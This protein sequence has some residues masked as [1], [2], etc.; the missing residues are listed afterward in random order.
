M[1]SDDVAALERELTALAARLPHDRGSPTAGRIPFDVTGDAGQALAT[2]AGLC[3]VA[4]ST[5]NRA[6]GEQVRVILLPYADWLVPAGDLA[7]IGPLAGPLGLLCEGLDR[8]DQAEELLRTAIT[9]CTELEA[10]RWLAAAQVE[11]ASFYQRQGTHLATATA[12]LTAALRSATALG[13]APLVQLARQALGGTGTGHVRVL[14]AFEVVAV[15]GRAARWPSRKARHLLKVLV[16]ARG[17]AVSREA[18]H[19]E[20]WPGAEAAVLPNRFAVAVAAVRR[21]L[22]PE[23]T[24]PHDYFVAVDGPTVRLRVERLDVDVET[25]LHLAGSAHPQAPAE[26]VAIHRGM[27]FAEEPCAEWAVELRREVELAFNGVAHRLAR[28]HADT[29]RHAAAAALYGRIV[30]ADPY[31]EVAL[32]AMITSLEALGALA[33]AAERRRQLAA[34]RG[35]LSGSSRIV[36]P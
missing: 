15:D 12:L 3:Q 13:A 19:R 18:C 30:E 25:F 29:G 1:M 9:V 33:A 20:L 36:G 10:R 21:T 34:R 24:L 26:A 31:N 4:T 23:R 28:Q 16:A 17:S 2:L 8:P 32:S 6:L 27:P 35:E 14:G 7:A 11:L 5:G 22:D